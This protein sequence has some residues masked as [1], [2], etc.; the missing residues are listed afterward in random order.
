MSS[1]WIAAAAVGDAARHDD[2]GALGLGELVEQ[3]A[4]ECERAEVVDAELRLESVGG[5]FTRRHHDARVVHQHIETILFG[6]QFSSGRNT[7]EVA[8]IEGDKA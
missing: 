2:A 1:K 5:Q 6:D 8:L 7:V 4:C 3:L